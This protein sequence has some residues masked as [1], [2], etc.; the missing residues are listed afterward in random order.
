DM[1]RIGDWLYVLGVNTLNEHLSYITIRG[2]RKRDHPQSFSYHTPWW[3]SYNVMAEYFT[4]LSLAISAGREVNGVLVIEPTSTSWMYQ[5]DPK[6]N[7]LGNSFQKLVTDLSKAQVEYDIGCEDIIARNGEV[8]NKELADEH[9]RV[10]SRGLFVVG[11]RVYSTIVLPPGT[12]NLNS[13]T[14]KLFERYLGFGGRVLC[15]GKPPSFVD[16]KPSAEPGKLA[17]NS[18]WQQ[19]D[20]ADLPEK[21]RASDGEALSI[22]QDESDGGILFHQRRRLDDG[23]FLFLTNTSIEAPA[24]GQIDASAKSIERWDLATGAISAYPFVAEKKGVKARFELPPC[25][26][27]LL[28]L[29][30]NKGE[31]ANPQVAEVTTIRPASPPKIRRIEPNVL[32]LDYVDVTA[33]GETKKDVYFYGANQFVFQKNGMDRNPWDSSVQL[34]DQLITKK[35]PADSGFEATYR[36]TIEGQ[37]PK[38]LY[39][40]VERPDLYAITCNGKPITAATGSWWLDKAFGKI[41]LAGAAKPGDNVVTIKA[42]PMTIYHELEPAYLLGE[43][44]LKAADKGH[45]VVADAPLKLGPWNEQGHPFYATGVV[46]TETFDVAKPAGR[47]YVS[48]PQWYGSVAKVSVN[49]S[50]AGHIAWQPW[51]CD[52]T[53]QI[54]P[55][56]NEIG[57]VVIGTLKNT[58][59]PHHGNPGTGRA[60]PA[61]FRNGPEPGPPPGKQYHTLGYGLFEPFVLKRTGK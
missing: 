40:V 13:P 6:L 43:F 8:G 15:C 33:G 56:R 23:D 16:G 46:Y 29:S 38:P 34:H 31:I 2:A 45:V 4:R 14:V 22:R 41:D 48:L 3:D 18:S 57:V 58:L 27:L 25:G 44:R 50:P 7:E 9:G 54:K 61:M 55:G 36:F 30:Q 52:V 42:S 51:Q 60:W 5:G 59:G 12:E 10:A 35:F 49:G 37:V 20:A 28:F 21:L 24:S 32:T 47:Y 11:Q 19:I 17:E 26:S 39:I 1:K 53:E